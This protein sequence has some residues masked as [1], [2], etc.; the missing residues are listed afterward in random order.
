MTVEQ[1]PYQSEAL[2]A[3]FADYQKGVRRMLNLMATGT[4]KT[5]VIGWLKEKFKEVLPGQMLVLA[6]T[7]ELVSQNLTKIQEENP[8]LKVRKEMAGEYADTDSDIISASVATLGRAGSSRPA[9]FNWCGIDKVVIDEAHHSVAES[10]GR[11]L[12]CAGSLRPDTHKLLLGVTATNQRPDGKALSDIFEKVS[13]TYSIR[14]AVS[15]GWLVP[16]RGYRVTTDTSLEDIS[17]HGGDFSKSELSR[18]VD[19]P[20]R[21]R[22]IVEQWLKLGESR[23]TL[24]FTVDI[25]HAKN[26]ANEFRNRGVSAEAVWGDDPERESKLKRFENGEINVLCNC[27]VVMEGYDCPSIE[28]VLLARPTTSG[29]LFTQMVGRGTRLFPGKKDLIV[30]DVVDNTSRHS[31]MTLP[32]LMGLSRTLDLEGQQLLKVVEEIETLQEQHPTI[33]FSKMLKAGELKTIVQS[34]NLLDVRFPKE[35]E[36]NSEFTWFRAVE[37]GYKILVPKIGSERAG[38]LRMYENALGQWEITGRIKDVDLHAFRPSMEEAF[39]ACDEQ[40]RKRIDKLAINY[41]LREATWHGKPVTAGQKGMLKRL[42]PWRQFDFHL[43]NS[44]QASRLISERLGRKVS[45]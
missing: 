24:A 30:I 8:T 14:Q 15:D 17:V 12:D 22:L 27:Q 21:N 36:E 33:D 37:G 13:Y 29:L 11:V 45:K 42:F 34:V 40:I 41:I 3:N 19:T 28:T 20:E 44:G 25:D 38:F 5:R 26:L 32:T 39:K 7:D 10:Y 1:R 6:H 35:C 23:K 16:I 31:L 9:R 4:G 2:A 43:M 18:G